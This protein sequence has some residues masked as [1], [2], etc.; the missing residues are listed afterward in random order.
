MYIR[1]NT[2][3]SQFVQPGYSNIRNFDGDG[4]DDNYDGADLERYAERVCCREFI[5]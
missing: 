1:Y 5:Y 4:D 2:E 3:Q